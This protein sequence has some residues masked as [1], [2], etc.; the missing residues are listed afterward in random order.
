MQPPTEP[1][2][3]PATVYP[4][5]EGGRKSKVFT[6]QSSWYNTFPWLHSEAGVRAVLCF[7][8]MTSHQICGTHSVAKNTETAFVTTGFWNWKK[9]VEKF[10]DMRH[11]MPT[12]QK[13]PII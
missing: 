3:A 2:H 9:A 1:N 4:V 6:F 11:P 5:N 13:S 12:Q 7:Y 10:K 8:C